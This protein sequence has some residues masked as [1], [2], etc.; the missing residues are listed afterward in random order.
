MKR[1][2]YPVILLAITALSHPAAAERAPA[3]DLS[4]AQS[5]SGAYLAAATARTDNDFDAAVKYYRDA[6]RFDPGNLEI[7]EE[8]LIALI[9]S[10]HFEEALPFAEKLKTVAEIERVSRVAL[11][12]RAIQE[13]RYLQA[14]SMLILSVENELERLLTG[15]M[16][17]WAQFGAGEVDHALRSVDELEGKD[18]YELFKAYHGALIA[19]AAGR[20]S[21]AAKRFEYGM[22][23]TAGGSASPQTYLRMAEAYAGFLARD[24]K[25]EDALATIDRGLGIAPQNPALLGLLKDS[26]KIGAQALRIADPAAGTAEILFNLGTAINRDGAESFAALYLEMAR[27]LVPNNAAVNFELGGIAERLGNPERAIAYYDNVPKQS[28]YGRL[29]HLQKGLNL[30]D[31]ERNDEAKETLAAAVKEDP[32]EYR[33]Y[34]ALG[35]VHAALKEFAEAA[36]LYE[37]A[38]KNI[39]TNDA[40]F[41]PLFYRLGIAYE[42]TNQWEK[43]EAAFK[44][45]LELSPNQPD[46]LNYLGYSW[47]DMNMNL[48]EGLEMIR[49]AVEMRPRDGYIVDSLGWA[50]YRLGRFE[51]AVVELEKSTDLRPRDA[52]INDH[53]GDAYWR[54][55]RKLE[56]TYQW[57]RAL[58]MEIERDDAA[59]I[60]AKLAASNA[61]GMTPQVA[62]SQADAGE[63]GKTA[64]SPNT[65]NGG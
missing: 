34:L 37:Q 27:A 23:N 28:F 7:Q 42:R 24:G 57:A 46:V 52:I 1:L 21:E 22:N 5:L 13:R 58:D 14:D 60:E 40:T 26:E 43:A 11:G 31:M 19:N 64:A 41:W 35:G 49:K 53:L 59:K 63:P 38:V 33:G 20:K 65:K 30:S 47:I 48:E 45:A 51:E 32:T 55:G 16:R 8:L 50:Y 36:E 56:A 17:S 3:N 39:D 15:I 44:H 9:T 2:V 6:L 12:I 25:T 10:G 61:T 62:V 54:V 29:A 4:S 18:W